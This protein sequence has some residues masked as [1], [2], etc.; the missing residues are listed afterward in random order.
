MGLEM[1]IDTKIYKV[2]IN[3]EEQYSIWPVERDNPL[4]WKNVGKSGTKSDCLEYIDEVWTDMRPLSLRAHMEKL[5][6][7]KKEKEHQNSDSPDIATEESL[8]SRLSSGLHPVEID[9]IERIDANEIRDR[10]KKGY[11][12]IKFP[13]TRGGTVLGIKL[14]NNLC[15]LQDV[16]FE[17]N[18]GSVHL[19]GNLTLNYVDVRCIVDID[20]ET[21]RGTGHLIPI[22]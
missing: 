6:K 10:I 4:G 17:R 7:S 15:N 22:E 9:R 2:V 1:K 14:E 5:E 20:I 12:H 19:E 13:L 21:K 11:I 3:H 18:S 8:V 16:D